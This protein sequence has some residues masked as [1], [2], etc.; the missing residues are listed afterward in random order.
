MQ[1]TVKRVF[2]INRTKIDSSERRCGRFNVYG[3]IE[4]K[5]YGFREFFLLSNGINF[6]QLRKAFSAGINVNKMFTKKGTNTAVYF[7]SS[8]YFESVN[9]KAALTGHITPLF[10]LTCFE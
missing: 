6:K 3:Q 1:Q 10:L 4:A 7:T 2:T 5:R 8:V 9:L